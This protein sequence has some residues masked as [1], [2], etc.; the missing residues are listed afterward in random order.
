MRTKIEQLPPVTRPDKVL[1]RRWLPI[2]PRL[3]VSFLIIIV[4]TGLIGFVAVKQLRDLSAAAT[5][6]STL[7]LPEVSTIGSLRTLLYRQRD[8]EQRLVSPGDANTAADLATLTSTLDQIAA[9]R[10][11][12]L[13]LEPHDAPGASPNDTARIEQFSNGLLQSSANSKQI[14]A[15]VGSGK[16]GEASALESQQGPLLQSLLDQT[17]QLR[18]LEQGESVSAAVEVGQQSSQATRIILGLM[19]FSVPLSILFALLITRSLTQPLSALLHATEAMTAGD[20]QLDPQIV[21]GDELGQ[22]ATA[23]NLMRLNLRSM[24]ATLELERQQTEAII[25]ASAD[26]VMLVDAERTILQFNP[27]AERMSGWSKYEAVGRHCWEVFGCRGA[28]P[29]Q[30]EEHDRTCPLALALETNTEQ[31]STEMQAHARNGRRRW[32]AVSSA[33]LPQSEKDHQ[34]RRLVIGLHDISELKEVEQLKSDFVATVS[35]ELRAPLSTVMGS[36]ESLGLLDP[37]SDREAFREVVG[38]LQQQTQRLRRVIE[39]VLQLTRV[40]AGRLQVHLEPLPVGAFLNTVLDNTRLAWVGDSRPLTLQ[41]PEIEPEVWGDRATLEIVVQN[42]LENARKY[43]PPGS[44]IQTK[45]EVD[46][47]AGRVQIRVSDEGPGI[48]PD[49]LERIFEPFSRGTH[50]S[51]NWTRGY[52]LGL[53]I[54]RELLRAHSGEIWAENRPE[55]GA[56]FV[57]SLQAVTDSPETRAPEAAERVPA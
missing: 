24:I 32:F 37:A 8:L 50:S 33:P 4:L 15:L 1:Q 16:I 56:C 27:A 52:G 13:S 14:Q 46:A 20:L 35:H 29:E 51:S 31:W 9:R 5:E 21:Q 39:E 3:L 10:A 11:K 7:D 25:D 18:N 41:T 47:A 42:L 48:P 43:S 44:P 26:G 36:V 49:Q 28:T 2:G 19:L 57:C 22:V 6:L 30:A 54:A 53:Y 38:I 45:V 17:V 34:P 40:E 23:F 55:G 12:M